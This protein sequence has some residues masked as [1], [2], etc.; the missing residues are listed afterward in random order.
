MA[1]TFNKKDREKKRRKRR[2]NKAEKKA[3]RKAEGKS[4]NE[5]MY[6]DEFGNFTTEAPDPKQKSKIKQEDIAISIPKQE[7]VEEES[8]Y[9]SGTVKFFNYD[10][11]YGFIVDDVTGQSYFA[12]VNNLKDE[13]AENDKVNFEAGEGPKGPVALDVAL[14]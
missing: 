4:G 1:D 14:S 10:K 3:Q 12:H 6:V 9:R 11:G 7:E 5:I 8:P 13:V 2:E